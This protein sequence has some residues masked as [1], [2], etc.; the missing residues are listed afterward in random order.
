MLAVIGDQL[1]GWFALGCVA[2]IAAGIA[3]TVLLPA[4]EEIDLSS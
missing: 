1:G 2:A 3:G 4:Q